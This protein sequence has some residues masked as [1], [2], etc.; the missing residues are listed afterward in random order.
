MLIKCPECQKEISD[1]SEMCIHC[2]YPIKEIVKTQN[3]CMIN[4][5]DVDLSDV[6]DKLKNESVIPSICLAGAMRLLSDTQ[7]I[8]LVDAR[9][10]C[11]I[12]METG[13]PPQKYNCDSVQPLTMP[14]CPKCNS[15]VITAGQRGYSIITGF[16]GSGDT[17]N[18]CS[19][20]GHKW[21]PR[22]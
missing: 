15:T 22:G 5:K 7:H 12:I 1:K 4:N 6:I 17:V 10:I 2:G 11:N 8:S 20:C 3:H 18:R 19:N 21:K 9:E 13:K 14:K 16:F